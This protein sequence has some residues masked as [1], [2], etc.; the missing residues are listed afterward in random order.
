M[1]HSGSCLCGQTKIEITGESF[2]QQ[3]ICHCTD[4]RH[5][6]GS[7]FSANII[8]AK[9]NLTITGPVK[10]YTS[11]ADSGNPVTRIFCGT[12]GSPISHYSPYFGDNQPVQTGNF[13]DFAD[14]PISAEV[15]VKDRWVGLGPVQGAVQWHG[16]PQK[17]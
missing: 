4:Y 2:T 8:V 6:S 7:A 15:Y 5:T 16:M 12:C 9:K 3:V 14:I 1:P 10:E 13:M 11:P 17:S